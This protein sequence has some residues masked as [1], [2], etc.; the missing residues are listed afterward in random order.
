MAWPTQVV[1]LRY[2]KVGAKN[3]GNKSKEEAVMR[4]KK[5]KEGLRRWFRAT[6]VRGGSTARRVSHAVASLPRVEVSV[7]TCVP[8]Y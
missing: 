4:E 6:T 2:L 8:S 3:W 1:R 5:Y 7:L